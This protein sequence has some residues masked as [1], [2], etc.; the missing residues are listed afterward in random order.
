MTASSA[1]RIRQEERGRGA[2]RGNIIGTDSKS[3]ARGVAPNDDNP[4]RF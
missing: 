1:E 2:A 4:H 3:S